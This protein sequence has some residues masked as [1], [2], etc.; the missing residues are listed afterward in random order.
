ML[1]CVLDANEAKCIEPENINLFKTEII[2]RI[3]LKE[4]DTSINLLQQ[5]IKRLDETLDNLSSIKSDTMWEY[6]Y[7]FFT[8]EQS[9]ARNMLLKIK[10]M[11]F[12]N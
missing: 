11:H 3:R 8:K 6:S 5:Y 4:Y 7:N 9:W 12:R 2:T 10:G 1:C